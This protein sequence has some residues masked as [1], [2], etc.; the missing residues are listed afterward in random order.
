MCHAV[1]SCMSSSVSL[2]VSAPS[3]Q[4]PS[5]SWRMATRTEPDLAGGF[6]LLKRN[7]SFLLLLHAC[8]VWGIAVKLTSQPKWL[9][10]LAGCNLL[11]F[12]RQINFKLIWTNELRLVNWPVWNDLLV[13]CHKTTFYLNWCYMHKLNWKLKINWIEL[14]L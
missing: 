2:C 13:K 6:F 10:L 5:Q 9:S 4:T 11:G 7:F 12:L 1:C 3:S 8:L 14:K